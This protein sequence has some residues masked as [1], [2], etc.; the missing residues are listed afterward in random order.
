MSAGYHRYNKRILKENLPNQL[1]IR[2]M[3]KGYQKK[4]DQISSKY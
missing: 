1:G 3:M 2:G 4:I